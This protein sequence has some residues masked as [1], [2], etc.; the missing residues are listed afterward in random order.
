MT[1][2]DDE[3]EDVKVEELTLD[4]LRKDGD[5]ADTEDKGPGGLRG[6]GLGPEGSRYRPPEAP[7]VRTWKPIAITVILLI[8]AGYGVFTIGYQVTLE[9]RAEGNIYTMWGKV[10][11]HDAVYDQQKEVPIAGVNVSVD[12]VED[13]Y[14][15]RSDGK[16]RIRDIPG[17]KFTIRFYKR[18][19]N[20]AV[21]TVYDSILYTDVSEDRAATFTVPV[22]NLAPDRDRPVYNGA[23][24]VQA[25]VIDWPTSDTVS[26]RLHASAFDEDLTGFS[27]QMGEN[28]EPLLN[29]GPYSNHLNYSFSLGGDQSS[30][31]I[32]VLDDNGDPYA[33]TILAIPEHP[34]GPGGWENTDYPAVAA[35]VRGGT[36]TNGTDR[37]VLVHSNGATE[38]T[39]RVDD[40]AWSDW[41]AMTDGQGE[42][43]WTPEG[44][45]GQFDIEVMTRNETQVNGTTATTTLTLDTLPP[46]MVPVSTGGPAV[47]NEATFDPGTLD[48]EFIRYSLPDGSWSEW[49]TYM[50]EVLVKIN[51][52]DPEAEKAT[53]MFQGMDLAGNV[54]S[55]SGVVTIKHQKEQF[56]DDH[57]GFYGNLMICIPIQAVGILLAI[58]GAMMAWKRKRPTM[59]MLG[60]MGALLAGYG[61]IG[62]IIAAAAL[63]IVMTS[64][65]EFEVPGPAPER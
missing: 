32:K 17:G 26:L 49:Q 39:Y 45:D 14:V 22:E 13:T 20:E 25:E 51:D 3:Q 38:M 29:M 4:D 41:M 16:F 64:R 53:V 15:T 40:S 27:V 19:W 12:G 33:Q 18:S 31:T 21:N 63:V 30:L 65:E 44:D 6:G 5:S 23:H 28:N 9:G 50:D 47:T 56:F 7:R 8:G 35:Y 58:F 61:I 2:A 60:A 10:L 46:A 52:S 48:A 57:G 62:A 59:V 37:T 42:F 11:D 34:L 1:G 55:A 24:G 43:V 54:V 36:L